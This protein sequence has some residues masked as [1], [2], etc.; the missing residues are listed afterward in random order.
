M[1]NKDLQVQYKFKLISPNCYNVEIYSLSGNEV[2]KIIQMIDFI[3]MDRV[4]FP[5]KTK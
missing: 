5:T 3:E 2:S 4:F 1:K